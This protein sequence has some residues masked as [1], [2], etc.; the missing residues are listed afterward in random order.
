MRQK[1]VA[2]RTGQIK[3]GDLVI[4]VVRKDIRNLNVAVYPPEGRVRVSSPR[5]VSDD[6]IRLAVIGKLPWIRRQQARFAG[7]ERQT[8][9]RYVSG[10]SHYYL[11]RRY[12]LQVL[13]AEGR[14]QGVEV[15]GGGFLNLYVR[16]EST[17]E[18]RARVLT[19]WYRERLKETIPAL[20]EKWEPVMG[21]EVADWGVK[22]MKTRWGSCNTRARRI[23]LN[24]DLTQKPPRCL[25]YVVVH[26]MVHLLERSHNER[27]HSLMTQLLPEWPYLRKELND[28]PLSHTNW[29]CYLNDAGIVT[30]R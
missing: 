26:E 14:R 25:E 10:E 15:E 21:I 17:V 12:R 30:D 24:L 1:G 29:E 13:P 18:S 9:R 8:P 16:E 19:G 23:W 4:E 2:G 7:Q 6:T 5:R 11:G 20:I 22:R 27:F 3:V 28:T